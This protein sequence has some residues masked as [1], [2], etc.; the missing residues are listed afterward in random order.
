[1]Q[2]IFTYHI[3]KSQGDSYSTLIQKTR[4][5]KSIIIFGFDIYWFSD[6]FKFMWLD[7]Q[8]PIFFFPLFRRKVVISGFKLKS[9][10][11]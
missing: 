4:I 2:Y 3:L 8:F 1:M 5:I 9:N 7:S 11:R 10:D 6:L